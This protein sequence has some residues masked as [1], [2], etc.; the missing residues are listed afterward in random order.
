MP[1]NRVSLK[2]LM[3]ENDYAGDSK[4][5]VIDLD[6]NNIKPNPYQPRYIFDEQKIEELAASIKENGLIQPIIVKKMNGYYTIISGE[7]RYRASIKAGLK[8]I[9]AI[10][11]MY[12]KSKMIELALI[13]NLQREDLTP[14]EEAKAYEQIMRELNYTHQELA[15]RVGKSRSYVTNMLG[16]LNLP[17]EVLKLVDEGKLSMGHARTLSKIADEKKILEIAKEV[18]EKGL[19]VRQIEEI[20]SVEPKKKEI[21]KSKRLKEYKTYE[22]TFKDK[23]NGRLKVSDGK[24][25]ISLDNND[26]LLEIL[27]RLVK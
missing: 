22:K 17:E 12:E 25:V 16:I 13:E 15:D 4:E 20:S 7:R 18:A 10:V 11:R 21:K 19:S 2:A 9:P 24:I 26:Y 1:S 3:E 23:Y 5:E 14:V 6:I 8:S 27:D